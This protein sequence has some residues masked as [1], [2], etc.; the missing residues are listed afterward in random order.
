MAELV[1]E[2]L[3]INVS[4]EKG[5]VK[6]PVETAVLAADLGIVGDAHAEPGIKQVSLL[7]NESVDKMREKTDSPLNFGDFAENITT[8]GL[9]LHEMPIGTRFTIG[10]TLLEVSKI[11][12]ECHHG[13]AIKVKVGTC[14]MPLEGIFAVVK[15]GGE[16]RRG[17]KITVPGVML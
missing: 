3:S 7:A 8:R 2:V 12:K 1:G 11:G 6:T 9:A 13:C 14:I 4:T 15:D 10:G 5:V 17:D 16:I